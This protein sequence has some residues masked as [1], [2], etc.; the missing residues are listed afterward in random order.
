LTWWYWLF[1]LLVEKMTDI[2]ILRRSCQ[3]FRMLARSAADD[4][5]GFSDWVVPINK[6]SSTYSTKYSTKYITKYHEISCGKFS[7]FI[8]QKST[9]KM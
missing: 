6:Y 5:V 8:P 1:V 7:Y 4:K 3:M 9:Y 2:C